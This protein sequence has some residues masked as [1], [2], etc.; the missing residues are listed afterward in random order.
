VSSLYQDEFVSVLNSFSAVRNTLNTHCESESK[1]S[2]SDAGTVAG[3]ASGGKS[4]KSAESL[5]WAG[6]GVVMAAVG[7]VV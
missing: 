2:D 5:A 1:E 6:A 4:A 3:G 7:F